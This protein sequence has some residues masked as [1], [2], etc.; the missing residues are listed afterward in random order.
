MAC[1]IQGAYLTAEY[2]EKVYTIAGLEFG[3]EAGSIMII[4]RALYGL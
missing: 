2:R 4:K 1:D 3:S